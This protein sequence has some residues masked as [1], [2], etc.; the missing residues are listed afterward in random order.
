MVIP[1][2]GEPRSF[3]IALAV[4]ASRSSPI[5]RSE[6]GQPILSNP[7]RQAASQVRFPLAAVFTLTRRLGPE[8]AAGQACSFMTKAT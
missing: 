1:A 8:A 3:W 2:E 5:N 7:K 4:T 6:S